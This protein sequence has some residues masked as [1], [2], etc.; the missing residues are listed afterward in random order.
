MLKSVRAIALLAVGALAL[1]A[2]G[3][4]DDEGGGES[5]G[6]KTLVISSDLPLQGAS[7][8]TANAKNNEIKLYLK[9]VGN[10]AGD[11]NI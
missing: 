4:G 11:S 6:G 7:A 9:Q 3:G 5:G 8:D 2:C 10:K 1:A